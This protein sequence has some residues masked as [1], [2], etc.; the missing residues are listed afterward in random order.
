MTIEK[1]FERFEEIMYNHFSFL[2]HDASDLKE[3][4][5]ECADIAKDF[6]KQEAINFEKWCCEA[7]MRLLSDNKRYL[8]FETSKEN[9]WLIYQS[10]K[11]A[12]EE[13]Q[14]P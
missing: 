13:K 6:A 7:R 4:A 5:K 14:K 9:L 3:D 12:N 11:T 10:E 1:I 2:N 8:Y